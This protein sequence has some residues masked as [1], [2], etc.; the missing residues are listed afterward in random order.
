MN[1]KFPAREWALFSMIF[2]IKSSGK[3]FLRR[4]V[5]KDGVAV[6]QLYPFSNYVHPSNSHTQINSSTCEK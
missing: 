3:I 2:P 5:V 6:P 4:R 1:T